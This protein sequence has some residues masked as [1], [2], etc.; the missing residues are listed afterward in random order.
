MAAMNPGQTAYF[1]GEYVPTADAQISILTHAFNYGTGIFE[2][3]RGYYSKE[4]DNIFI[5]RL[6]EHVDRLV[7]NCNVYCNSCSLLIARGRSAVHLQRS[8]VINFAC[9][10]FIVCISFICMLCANPQYET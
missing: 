9:V 1:E 3:I 7:R 6:W 8:W 10:I 5:F 4:E 2:G